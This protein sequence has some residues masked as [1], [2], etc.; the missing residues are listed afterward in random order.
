MMGDLCALL[1]WDSE[2]WGFPVARIKGNKLTKRAVEEVIRWC[3]KHKVRCLY[4]EADGTCAET[5]QAVENNG[6]RF[7]D[8]R[9]D[10]QVGASSGALP[11]RTN[12]EC[13]EATQEDLFAMERLARTAHVDTRFFKDTRFDREKAAEMYA[14]WIARDF[15]EHKV[16]AATAADTPR[17]V[18]GYATAN[19]ANN[20]TGRIGLVAVSPA[21]RGRGLG[22]LL[23][24]NAVAWCQSSGAKCVRVATQGTNIAALRLYESSG[25]KAADVKI[26]FHRWFN[27]GTPAR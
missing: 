2:H 21:A 27:L 9:V 11:T 20:K 23:V 4:F 19:I 25:F 18:L 1:A 6:F 14:L 24:K 5:L 17:N 13:R 15:R 26:W 12:G 16:F 22:H 7:V 3:G 8:I 10:M